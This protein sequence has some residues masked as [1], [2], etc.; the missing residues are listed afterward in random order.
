MVGKEINNSEF[1]DLIVLTHHAPSF[2]MLNQ[3]EIDDLKYA[4]ATNLEYL[5]TDQVKYWINGHT[6]YSTENQIKNTICLSNC[7]GYNNEKTNFDQ[8]KYINFN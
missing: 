6:H 5:M 4:Y 3:I 2:K 7:K 8:S 1:Y